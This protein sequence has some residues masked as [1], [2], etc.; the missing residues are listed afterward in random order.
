MNV[1]E[2]EA[3]NT[4][5]RYLFKLDEGMPWEPRPEDAVVRSARFLAGRANDTLKAGVRESDIPDEVPS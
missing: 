1:N 5:L 3:V 2:S 4:L